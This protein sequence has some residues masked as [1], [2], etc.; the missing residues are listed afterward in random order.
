MTTGFGKK[1]IVSGYDGAVVGVGCAV[2]AGGTV[3]ACGDEG[4]A[5]C[6]DE[7]GP[8]PP[9]ADSA[10]AAAIAM[11]GFL[12]MSS[13]VCRRFLVVADV[14][15][16]LRKTRR[17]TVLT[18]YRSVTPPFLFCGVRQGKRFNA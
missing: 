15:P 17:P 10:R 12:M 1:A 14:F 2:G 11:I 5:A 3:G 4:G 13:V 18:H 6:A 9:H 16:Q 7:V 8:P